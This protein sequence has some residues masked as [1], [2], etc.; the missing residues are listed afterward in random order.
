MLR[1]FL[2]YVLDRLIVF[3]AALVA[4]ALCVRAAIP[5]IVSGAPPM[6]FFWL[7]VG[8]FVVGA[9]AATVWVEVVAP[10]RSGGATPA[11]GWLGLRIQTVRGNPPSL[12]D[13]LLRSL[14]FAVDGLLMGLVGAVFIALTPRHQRVGDIVTRTVVVRADLS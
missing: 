4:A 11:M 7:P 12:G 2:Q 8:G 14:L 9:L 13:L 6:L 10:L 1:R 3:M 5:L